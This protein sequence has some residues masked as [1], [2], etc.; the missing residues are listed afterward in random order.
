VRNC[1]VVVRQKSVSVAQF[2]YL[3][4]FTQNYLSHRAMFKYCNGNQVHNKFVVTMCGL[5]ASLY[6]KFAQ[7]KSNVFWLDASDCLAMVALQYFDYGQGSR[8]D[9]RL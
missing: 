8:G 6:K 2:I 3:D 9:D 5:W 1:V 7:F 4:N